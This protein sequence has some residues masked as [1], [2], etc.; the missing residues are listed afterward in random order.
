MI[1]A[2]SPFGAV[3]VSASISM[4]GRWAKSLLLTSLQVG[5]CA[6][7]ERW[8]ART[9]VKNERH[10]NRQWSKEGSHTFRGFTARDT[11]KVGR[12]LPLHNDPR[13]R[14]VRKSSKRPR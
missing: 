3:L 10:Q 8:A 6:I 14:E 12:R 7:D 2:D 1:L 5:L 11:P 13:R 9:L 4:G